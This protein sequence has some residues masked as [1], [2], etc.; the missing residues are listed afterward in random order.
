MRVV[1][2]ITGASGVIYG[3]RLIE[4]LRDRGI[5]A[6][7]IVS[8]AAELILKHEEVDPPG[9]CYGEE[10]IEAPIASGSYQFDAMVVVPCSMKTLSAIAN[11]LSMNLITRCA[12][13]ALKERRPLVLVPRETPLNT[14]HIENM[15]R[16]SKIGAVILPAMPAFYHAPRNIDDLVNFIGGKILDSLGVDNELYRRWGR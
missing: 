9:K 13:V 8:N 10:D 12:D 2:A 16:L 11:G 15:L 6:P 7:C 14:I 5:E 4:T 3:V 1:V